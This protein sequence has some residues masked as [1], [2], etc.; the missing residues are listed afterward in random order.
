MKELSVAEI[1]LALE[2][3]RSKYEKLIHN[4]QK[5]PSLLTGF[6]ERYIA[7]LKMR[8]NLTVFLLAEIEAVEEIFKREEKK[9]KERTQE[10]YQKAPPSFVEKVM[11]EN[12]KRY[13]LYPALKLSSDSDEEIDHLCGAAREFLNLYLPPAVRITE[14]LSHSVLSKKMNDIYNELLTHI[15]Y[16]G[17]VPLTKHYVSALEHSK[18]NTKVLFEYQKLIQ[19]IGFLL[20][21]CLDTLRKLLDYLEKSSEKNKQAGPLLEKAYQTKQTVQLFTGKSYYET[22]QTIY[23][24]LEILI[25]NFRLK[26]IKKI[27]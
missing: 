19:N 22:L 12:K 8:K 9:K 17:G 4:Y 16:D 20:N 1:N 2:K 6:H 25:R 27:H 21:S 5:S 7:A 13:G 15:S 18:D 24:R 10:K 11:N 14:T 26:D 3:I 23:S